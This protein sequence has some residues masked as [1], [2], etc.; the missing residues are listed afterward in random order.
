[1]VFFALW[2]NFSKTF[3]FAIASLLNLGQGQIISALIFW[4]ILPLEQLSRLSFLVELLFFVRNSNNYDL[5]VIHIHE[6]G[7]LAGV[8]VMLGK[9][10]G[11][12]VICKVRNTP[13]LDVIGYDVPFRRKWHRLRSK[14]CF[15]ALNQ[16]LKQELLAQGI[17]EGRIR[18]IPN[19]VELPDLAV[20][21]NHNIEVLYVGNFSQGQ[22]HK[23]FDTLLN[24]WAIVVQNIPEAC[25]TIVGRGDYLP[26]ERLA[27]RLSCEKSISFIGHQSDIHRYYSKAGIFVLP[28]R[29][30]G[31]SNALLEAQSWGMACVV[32]DIPANTA[33]IDDG[34]NGLCF[35]VEDYKEFSQKLLFVMRNEH[36]RIEFGRNARKKAEEQYDILRVAEQL[37]DYYRFASKVG[38]G[39]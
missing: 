28:S 31:M 24:A 36:K 12:P 10:W 7:W 9:R 2:L 17:T 34:I 4:L 21:S 25:L 16:S 11:I 13:A 8:G 19:G 26:W 18:V 20:K 14:A 3:F 39:L 37:V 38:D 33:V 29:Y 5:S 30:E 23:A 27:K 22:K 15:I 6:T 35:P 32:S 1:M